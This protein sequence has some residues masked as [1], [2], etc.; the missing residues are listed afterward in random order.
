MKTKITEYYVETWRLHIPW[1]D[2]LIR[3]RSY[4]LANTCAIK[5]YLTKYKI[6]SDGNENKTWVPLKLL[7]QINIYVLRLKYFHG[8]LEYKV[9]NPSYIW[10]APATPVNPAVLKKCYYHDIKP[11]NQTIIMWRSFGKTLKH[12]DA[13]TWQEVSIIT[14]LKHSSAEEHWGLRHNNFPK[15]KRQRSV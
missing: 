7:K 1:P 9:A 13:V 10:L 12:V 5:S 15:K 8:H 11:E 14:I 3:A 4:H 2:G 6:K